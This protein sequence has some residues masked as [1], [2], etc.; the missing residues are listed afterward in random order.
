MTE[1]A[2]AHARSIIGTFRYR[3]RDPENQDCGLR[4]RMTTTDA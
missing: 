3:A 4:G 1:H 2:A